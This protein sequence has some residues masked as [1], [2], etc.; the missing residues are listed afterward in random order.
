[1]QH[2]GLQSKVYEFKSIGNLKLKQLTNTNK[3]SQ[4][5]DQF[6]VLKHW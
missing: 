1:M 2:P 6:W 5:Y 4:H 3:N